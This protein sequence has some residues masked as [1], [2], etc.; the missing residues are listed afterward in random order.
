MRR[1]MILALPLLAA[2]TPNAERPAP[3]LSRGDAPAPNTGLLRP[4]A[5]VDPGIRAPLPNRSPTT[6]PVIPPNPGIQAR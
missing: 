2:C 4:E 6:T 1:W 5:G 3:G